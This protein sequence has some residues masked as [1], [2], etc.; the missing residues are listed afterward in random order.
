MCIV[1][2]HECNWQSS[3]RPAARRGFNQLF[4][5]L[6]VAAKCPKKLCNKY[7]GP[8]SCPMMRRGIIGRFP[9][10][11]PREYPLRSPW[12][13]IKSAGLN[14]STLS[15]FRRG[16][17]EYT[18]YAPPHRCGQ[19]DFPPISMRSTIH[20]TRV[21]RQWFAAFSTLVPMLRV[22]T[23]RTTSRRDYR[24]L[25]KAGQDRPITTNP[26]DGEGCWFLPTIAE[27][28]AQRWV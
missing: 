11:S 3:H 5:V 7:D 27:P 14:F 17:G 12:D 10:T 16:V 19:A 15:S 26:S 20:T 13:G 24:L 22:E 8:I 21:C 9:S 4:S 23:R 18:Y 6:L 1:L 2:L 25:S 28:F